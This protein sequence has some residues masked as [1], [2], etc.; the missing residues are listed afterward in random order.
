VQRTGADCRHHPRELVA[1][2][3]VLGHHREAGVGVGVAR[4]GREQVAEPQLA[5]RFRAGVRRHLGAAGHDPAAELIAVD[6]HG[7]PGQPLGE[8]L[9][10]RRLPR[11]LNAGD[12][13]HRSCEH[14]LDLARDRKSLGRSNGCD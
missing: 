2:H 3:D 10:H 11:G 4:A 1:E 14:V 13:V 5:D 9:R 7:S 8:G 12:E 6:V